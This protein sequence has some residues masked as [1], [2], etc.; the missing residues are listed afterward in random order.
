MQFPESWLREFCNPPLN[1]AELA[2]LLTM[3]GME[4][5]ELRPAASPFTG[6]VVGEVLSVVRHPDAEQLNVCQDDVDAATPLNI[7]C[8]AP[9]VHVG[10]KVQYATI[11]T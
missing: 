3:A 9:N 2:D 6:V 1:T 5:E 10:I 7:V 8:G 11:N 4:V